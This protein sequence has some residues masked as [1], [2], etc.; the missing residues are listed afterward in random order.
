MVEVIKRAVL[1]VLWLYFTWPAKNTG[2][3]IVERRE[4]QRIN[5]GRVMAIGEG[6]SMVMQGVKRIWMEEY[7]RVRGKRRELWCRSG[8]WGEGGS[9]RR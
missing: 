8:S 6:R 7:L 1:I 4:R 5:E 2:G 9:E 3:G